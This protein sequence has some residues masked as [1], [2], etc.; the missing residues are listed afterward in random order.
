MKVTVQVKVTGGDSES[1]GTVKVTM[2][3]KVTVVVTVRVQGQ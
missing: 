2:M 3:V 1:A